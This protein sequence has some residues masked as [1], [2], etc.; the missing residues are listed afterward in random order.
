MDEVV[1][2]LPH[3]IDTPVGERGG[4]LSGGQRQRLAIARA[5]LRNPSVLL[6]DEATSALDPKTERAIAA[7]LDR[8]GEG[9]TTVAITHRLGTVV[10]YDLI[11]VLDQGRV[12]E[13]GTHEELL[14]HGGV[15]ATLWAEQTGA[16]PPVGPV[17]GQRLDPVTV[18]LPRAE[19][20]PTPA[21][22]AELDAELE[23]LTGAFPTARA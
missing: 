18:A 4:R 3:G 11:V 19:L 23:R 9:R 22:Q 10:D 13:Q 20:I 15:Y 2:N 1:A 12:V 8:A 16:P 17:G 21:H 7:T 6:L 5:L 14:A